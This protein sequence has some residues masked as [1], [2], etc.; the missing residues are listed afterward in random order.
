MPKQVLRH[1]AEVAKNF[2]CCTTDCGE[3][4]LS[5]R[6]HDDVTLINAGKYTTQSMSGGVLHS[7][8]DLE[9][10]FFNCGKFID[11]R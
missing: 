2:R 6:A 1:R 10:Q 3:K 9:N 8:P 5:A 4:F 11:K 7:S